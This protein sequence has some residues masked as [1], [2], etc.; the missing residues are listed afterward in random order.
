MTVKTTVFTKGKEKILKRH[1][2]GT[3]LSTPSQI[4]R[5][6]FSGFLGGGDGHGNQFYSYCPHVKMNRHQSLY[7]YVSKVKALMVKMKPTVSICKRISLEQPRYQHH[8]EAVL[9][10]ICHAV[11]SYGHT[12]GS[13]TKAV[14]YSHIE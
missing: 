11:S 4:F 6:I 5:E 7:K 9:A 12:A 8:P 13:Y 10:V 1:R 14:S 3:G 2:T